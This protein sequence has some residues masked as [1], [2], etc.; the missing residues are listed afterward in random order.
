[1]DP[2][3]AFIIRLQISGDNFMGEVYRVLYKD[4]NEKSQSSLILKVAPRNPA[5]REHMRSRDLFVREID[6][7][8]KV[9]ILKRK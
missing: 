4:A 8:D 6:L 2:K 5:R 1:M 3:N 9:S 7:Y